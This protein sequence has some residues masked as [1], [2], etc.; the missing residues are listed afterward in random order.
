MCEIDG[1]DSLGLDPLEQRYLQILSKSQNV[2]VRLNVMATMFGLPRQTIERVIESDLIRLGLVS[3][4]DAGR[5]L[6]AEG[7]EHVRKSKP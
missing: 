2:P 1:I 6:T 7:Q 4:S 3:K 5:M